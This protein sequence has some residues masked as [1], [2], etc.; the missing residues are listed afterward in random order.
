MRVAPLIFFQPWFNLNLTKIPQ[1]TNQEPTK[2]QPRT[3]QELNQISTRNQPGFNLNS[4]KNSTIFQPRANQKP[5][6]FQPG[7]NLHSTKIH[8][9]EFEQ[10]KTTHKLNSTPG[11][12]HYSDPGRLPSQ[13][14]SGK[15]R[16][17]KQLNSN[18]K[19]LQPRRFGRDINN[20]VQ[21][22][23]VTVRSSNSAF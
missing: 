2:K 13:R 11:G 21:G 7:F 19:R 1:R 18:P 22:A 20:G 8:S 23:L 15:S 4:T 9:T 14:S 5:T 3:N 10:D 16:N 17:Y 12:S 6:K